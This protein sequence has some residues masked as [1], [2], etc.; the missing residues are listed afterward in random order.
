MIRVGLLGT[1]RI[2][3]LHAETI[4]SHSESSLYAVSDI[5]SGSA[6]EIAVQ[7]G[8]ALKSSEEIISDPN[9]DAILIAT[10][11]DTHAEFIEKASL[12]GKSVF[13]EKPVDLSL[14]RA[15]E[16]LN[17]VSAEN[18]PVMIGFNRRF[19]PNFAQLKK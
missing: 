6:N 4:A 2:G 16:C 12:V 14:S 18:N 19:D 8:A 9:V 3:R 5:D 11:T 15:K 10:S 17:R 7:Y 1:G 13:C